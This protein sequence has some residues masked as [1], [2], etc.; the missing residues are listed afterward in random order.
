MRLVLPSCLAVCTLAAGSTAHAQRAD[1]PPVL[2]EA[3]ALARM[4][5]ADPRVH[6]ARLQ[7]DAVRAEQLER[8]RWPNPAVTFSREESAGLEDVFLTA[9]QEVALSGRRGHLRA[10]ARLAVEAADAGATSQV[11]ELQASLRRSFTALLVA[12]ERETV[13]RR[14]VGEMRQLV[15][16][17]RSREEAGEGA[18]YDRL[19]G[20]RALVDVESDLAMG[21]IA[22]ARAQVDLAS[23]LGPPVD[24]DALVVSGSLHPGPPAPLAV[25]IDRALAI[26]ADYRASDLAVTQHEAERRAARALRIPTPT[27]GYGLK[28]S[29]SG[30]TADNGSVFSVDVTVPLA[31]RG[32]SAVALATARA[33]QAAAERAFLRIRIETDVREA[34][35]TLTMEHARAARYRESI[36]D[37]AE[38]LAAIARLAYEEGGLG[39]LEL[40]DANRQ[41]TE[42]QLRVLEMAAGA[43]LAAI[44]LDRVTGFEVTP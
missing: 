37:T 31:N 28:R 27:V 21:S 26:R 8:T 33:S 44:E 36:V 18:R 19:R 29:A 7:V 17:L 30:T 23:F 34:H 3:D 16:I 42:A 2:T 14:S 5:A 15:E 10:A 9:R 12:Q 40:L 35:L 32:Q 25:V 24:P 11:R 38:P 1:S 22:R 6:A 20:Q 41:A 43:R 4:M 13:L 39:I